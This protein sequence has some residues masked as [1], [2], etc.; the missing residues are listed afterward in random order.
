MDIDKIKA[1]A[2]IA[3]NLALQKKTLFEQMRSRQTVVYDNHIFTADAETINL[4]KALMDSR[5]N[6][7]MYVIDRNHNPV[8]ISDPADFL[9]TLIARNQET[10]NAYHVYYSKFTRR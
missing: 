2:D 6:D 4:V 5:P 1:Q 9:E 3:H 8:K 7:A 10:I